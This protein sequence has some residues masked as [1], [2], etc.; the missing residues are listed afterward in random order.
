MEGCRV[1]R[2]L[3]DYLF[4][5]DDDDDDGDDDGRCMRVRHER[6]CNARYERISG[7]KKRMIGVRCTL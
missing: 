2:C 3:T 6:M 5:V 7:T 1:F 4:L